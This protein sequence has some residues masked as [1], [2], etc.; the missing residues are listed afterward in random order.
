MPWRP[1]ADFSR[2]VLQPAP[3]GPGA[4]APDAPGGR[5]RFSRHLR[6]SELFLPA[7]LRGGARGVLAAGNI[8]AVLAVV[9]FLVLVIK[10]LVIRIYKP[11]KELAA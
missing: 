5:V 11:W 8:H 2:G 7:G 4:D 3:L 6:R 9:L 10:I 1:G